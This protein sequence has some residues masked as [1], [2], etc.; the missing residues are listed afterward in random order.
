MHGN[1]RSTTRSAGE[2]GMTT[3]SRIAPIRRG[4]VAAGFLA[5]VAVS[6][7][8]G[9]ADGPDRPPVDPGD[10]PVWAAAS[11]GGAGGAGGAGG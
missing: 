10:Y 9:A 3:P 6:V 2:P 1:R 7:V 5:T 8:V 4:L 11:S